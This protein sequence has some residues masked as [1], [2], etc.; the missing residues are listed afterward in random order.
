MV[1][2]DREAEAMVSATIFVSGKVQGVY[3]RKFT[4]ENAQYLGLNGFVQ[5]M[6][7]GRVMAVAEGSR[8]DIR[9][10]IDFLHIGPQGS[11][12]DSVDVEWSEHIE[13][14]PDFTIR[15]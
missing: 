6:P 3:F 11:R 14:H 13:G 7:D 12:V 10:L 2:C 4:L 1:Q 8:A 5:N 15:R 9:T